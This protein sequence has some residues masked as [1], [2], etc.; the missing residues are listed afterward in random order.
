MATPPGLDSIPWQLPLPSPSPSPSPIFDKKL[1]F[2]LTDSDFVSYDRNTN[3]AY[4]CWF[5]QV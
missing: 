2:H 1:G 3:I 4:F 5:V